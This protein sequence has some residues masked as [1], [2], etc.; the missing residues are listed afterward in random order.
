M[1]PGGEL[2]F[3]TEQ[4]SPADQEDA[5]ELERIAAAYVDLLHGLAPT[6][7][8]VTDKMPLNVF[9]VGLVHCCLPRAM[10]VSCRRRPIDVALSI[11]RTF[12]NQGIGFPTG[13][14]A[15]AAAV[16]AV[17]RLSS[18]W[19]RVVPAARFHEVSHERLV[20]EPTREIGA[21]LSACGLTW[22]DACLHPERNARTVR[23][24]SRW[25][26]RQPITVP[27]PDAWRRY[28]PWL[29]AL[30]ALT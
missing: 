15:L 21:L 9:Q 6:A 16:Q 12:F 17:E 25:Q 23:T 8:R 24:P 22:N 5:E 13:G 29:G 14:A 3:W 20:S 28:E 19:R 18:H 26:V 30:S 10:I 1:H 4:A 2:P 7:G 11:Q 27:P